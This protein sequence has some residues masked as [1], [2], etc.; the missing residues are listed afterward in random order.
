MAII[1]EPN[2][3]ELS[4]DG[5]VLTYSTSSISGSGPLQLPRW[6]AGGQRVWRGDQDDLH[7]S[8]HRGHGH[9]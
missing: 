9:R 8:R 5:V 4:C 1:E 3:Y 2:L 6:S 7:G